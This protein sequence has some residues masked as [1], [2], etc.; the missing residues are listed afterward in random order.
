M[1][2][3]RP[4]SSGEINIFFGLIAIGTMHKL[5]MIVQITQV[6]HFHPTRPARKKTLSSKKSYCLM[7]YF[8]IVLFFA[9]ISLL[10]VSCNSNNEK[11]SLAMRLAKGD[12][13]SIESD[14][15][16]NYEVAVMGTKQNFEME[17]AS[18]VQ[19]DVL[20]ST[21]S[22]AELMM[23][24]KNQNIK[25]DYGK[26][27]PPS[28]KDIKTDSLV[29]TMIGKKLYFKVKDNKV[30]DV[31][32]LENLSALPDSAARFAN[33]LLSEE[34]FSQ[35]SGMIFDMYPP[36]EVSV[37]DTWSKNSN[38]SMAGFPISLTTKYTLKEV[39]NGLAY[40]DVDGAINAKETEMPMVP[41]V[42]MKFTGPTKG[43]VIVR[44]DDGYLS[45]SK[46]DMDIQADATMAGEKLS[47]KMKGVVKSKGK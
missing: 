3:P 17:S 43:T 27:I 22:G 9:A 37:G 33:E 14:T 42:K 39:K 28:A 12:S 23:T 44:T 13:F 20:D 19:Y 46:Y 34:T 25:M 30:S 35:M 45:E 21:A 38:F 41:G 47:M 31:R 7:K 8:S 16:L 2:W 40:I 36:N 10:Q 11:Y 5:G 15:K 4:Q 6:S 18:E 32:G 24:M 29:R 1:A 26:G